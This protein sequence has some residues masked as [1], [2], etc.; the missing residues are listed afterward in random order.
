MSLTRSEIVEQLR[1]L[2]GVHQVVIDE[3]TLRERSI[4]NFRKLQNIFNVYTGPFPAAVVSVRSTAEAAA[5]LAFADANGVN[6]VARTGGTA[7]EGGLETPVENSIVLDGGLMNQILTIDTYN[8][9]ATAQCGV[10]LQRLE[11]EVRK[12]GLT[13][14]H[15]PQSKPIASMGGL[16]ATRSIGQFSTLYGGI[17]DMV[18]GC[19][20]VFPG[21]QVSRIKNVP[22]RAAG[23][24]IRHLVIGNEGALCFITEVTVKLFPYMPENNTFVGWTMKDMKVGFEVLREVMV[25]GYKPSVARLYDYEDGQ[26]HFSNFVPADE[27]IVLFMA[28]GNE[29]IVKATAEGIREIAATHPGCTPVE[30][31][32]LEEWFA[33]LVWGPDKVTRED[34]RIRDT[35]NV[36]RTT[37]VSADWSSIQQI[38]DA[39][40]PRIRA[41]IKGITLLGGH[42]SHSYING[43]NMYFNYF[44]DLIDCEPVDE[45]EKYYLPIIKIIVEETLRFGGSI[46]H[47]HGIGKA[48]ARWVKDEY[49]SSY[50]MLAALKT[51]FDPNGVMNMGTIYPLT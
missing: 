32:H 34:N 25:A 49:G 51:A 45:T 46:V 7:T 40:I 26:L 1:A 11:D 22:R 21:G 6:V 4:D 41:E 29:G 24:D 3:Q 19:E 8:M 36:N 27:C 18:V 33:D 12:H 16:V 38:Y 44:Y 47:H 20:V 28:E 5:V 17:E 14:G 50:P 10:P 39:V 23:P 13:T 9:Q 30:A 37:E 48:R 2:V 35:R 15:S 31:H 43:T 42:S